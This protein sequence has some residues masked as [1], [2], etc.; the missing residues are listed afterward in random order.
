MFL[1]RARHEWRRAQKILLQ[2]TTS[3]LHIGELAPITGGAPG[4]DPL[5]RLPPPPPPLPAGFWPRSAGP[6]APKAP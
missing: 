4:P 3:K 2:R 6:W 5:R 1:Q